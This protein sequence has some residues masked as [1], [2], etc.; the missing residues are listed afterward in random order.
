MTETI[1]IVGAVLYWGY[2]LALLIIVAPKMEHPDLCVMVATTALWPIFA[3]IGILIL[4]W[5]LIPPMK[6]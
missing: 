3:V 5:E 6:G 1:I 4:A 2:A